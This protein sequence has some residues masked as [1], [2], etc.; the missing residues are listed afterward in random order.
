MLRH[1]VLLVVIALAFVAVLIGQAISQEQGRSGRRGASQRSPEEMRERMEQRNRQAAERLRTSLNASEEQWAVIQP[2][3]EKVQTLMRQMQIR[4]RRN[5][6]RTRGQRRT[7]SS[8][9]DDDAAVARPQSD[10]EKSRQT[11]RDLLEDEKSSNEKIE[12][13]LKDL[14]V[15]TTKLEKKLDKARGSLRKEVNL[16]QQAR[17][18]LIGLLD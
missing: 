17:L 5:R 8:R 2:R 7:P 9:R 1:R 11:L 13:A 10:I 6:F 12:S 16:R 4:Q 3:V 15:A 18:V 14:R